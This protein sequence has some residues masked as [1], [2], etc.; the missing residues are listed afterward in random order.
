MEDVGRRP[1][2][3]QKRSRCFPAPAPVLTWISGPRTS[4]YLPRQGMGERGCNG[5]KE[6]FRRW[7]MKMPLAVY[8]ASLETTKWRFRKSKSRRRGCERARIDSRDGSAPR[9]L[10]LVKKK[11]KKS[12]HAHVQFSQVTLYETA[13]QQNQAKFNQL[14]KREA[15]CKI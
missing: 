4:A 9:Y 2:S 11:K 13:I 7:E 14:I 5:W 15:K 10:Q 12:R 1:G 6:K 3:S 8:N